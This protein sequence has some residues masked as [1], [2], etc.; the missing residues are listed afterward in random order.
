MPG[1][2]DFAYASRRLVKS[3]GFTLAVVLSLALGIGANAAIFSVVNGLLF[4]PAGIRDPQGLVAPRVTYRKLNLDKI[5]MSAT[6]FADIRGNR[7]AFSSAAMADVDG[8]NYT[9]GGS[10]ERLEGALVT[11]QWFEVFG[12][13]PLLGRGFHREEDLPGANHVLVLSYA[14]WQRFFGGDH[15]VIGRTIELNKTPYRVI[16]VMPANFRWPAEADVWIPIGL[17]PQNYG[18]GNRFNENYFAVARLAPSV[19]YSRANSVVQGLSKRVLDQV[20]FA[21]ASQWSMVLEPLTEYI[22]GDLKTPMF[23]LL[24]AVAFVLLIACSNIAGL[25]LVRGTAGAR[26]LAIR[27]ALGASRADLIS[28]AATEIFMLSLTGTAL[29]FACAFG[30]LRGLLSLARAHLSTELFIR[31]DSHVLAFAA[32]A[33]LLSAVVFGLIP[34]WHISRLGQHYNQLKEG[35]RSDTEGHQRQALRSALVAGQIAL[36]LVLLVG[37]GLLLRTLAQLRNV[38]AGFNGRN[39]MTAS[40]ALPPTEYSDEKQVA[41]VHSA[42][43]QLSQTPGVTSAAAATAVPFSGG[44]PTASFSIEGRIVAPGDPGFHGSIRSVTPKYFQTLKIPLVAGRYFNDGDRQSGQPVAIIDVDMA[45]RYWPNQNPIGRRLR[46]NSADSWATI[47]G[48]VG[49]VKQT[50]LAADAGRGIYYFCLYQQPS[51]EMYLVTRGAGSTTHTSEAIRSAVRAVDPA[52]AVFD[53]KTMQER[54]SLALGPQQF[55]ARILMAFAGAALLLAAIG[56][57][58]VISYNVTRRTREIGIRTALGAG[59]S[60]ILI[61]IIGQAMRLVSVGLVSGL[62]A[63]ALLGRLAA[64]QLFEVSPFDPATFVVTAL[65]LTA[66]ALLASFIPAWRA[67]RVDPITALRNE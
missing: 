63:A 60:G 30:I 50:S 45:R 11:W 14:G 40:I 4:H 6:D 54:I 55:A 18:P 51:P 5:P 8:F 66:A 56:L 37:A 1:K 57:Y 47:V 36:A 53:V 59:R 41:F 64:T 29:G 25:M 28:Q 22:A 9:N 2:F 61:L 21:R 34:A 42:L 67:A 52:Q 15:A 17:A 23:I 43:D 7:A 24:G 49:H 13:K 16:G 65:V 12:S 48:I 32:C 39:V 19:S 35:G 38:D 46:H 27:T 31:I 10:P 62:L 33:G 20:P 3:P 26:E 44:D 58:G